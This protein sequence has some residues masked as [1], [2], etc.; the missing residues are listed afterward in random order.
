MAAGTAGLL[1]SAS[2]F[3][4]VVYSLVTGS[5]WANLWLIALLFAVALAVELVLP[6]ILPENRG[7]AGFR[8]GMARFGKGVNLVI[9]SSALLLVYVFGVGFI[10]LMSR[11][12]GKRF[13]S[14]K[15]PEGTAWKEKKGKNDYSEMF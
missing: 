4:L 15:A 7:V 10:W 9:V 12:A 6:K 5:L 3:A 14:I 2:V 1:F 13:V 11:L 8:Q